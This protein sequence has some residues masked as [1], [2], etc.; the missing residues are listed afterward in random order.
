MIDIVLEG[1]IDFK[2]AVTGIPDFLLV[3]RQGLSTHHI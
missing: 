3:K 1:S 2:K